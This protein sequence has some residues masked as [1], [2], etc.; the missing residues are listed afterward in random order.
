MWDEPPPTAGSNVSIIPYALGGISKNYEKKQPTEYKKNIGGDVKIAVTSSL[1]LDLTVNPDF[2]QTDVDQQIVNLDRYELFFP[3]KR[4]FFL[5][6]ADLFAN[7]GYANIRPFF[8]RRIGLNAPIRF[9]ARLS[10]KLNKDWRIGFM[11]M[12]TGSVAETGLPAQNFGVIALQRRVFAR[13]NIGFIFVNKQ[14]LNYTPGADSSKPVYSLYNRNA[15]L[16]YNLAS[17]NNQWTGKLL[18]LKSFNDGPNKK[19]GCTLPIFS[20]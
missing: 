19:I 10:G 17:A 8:S 6:N 18:F 2:S 11:D 13:S 12:Q 15:G 16:E 20:T 7:F 1:N 3:E 4:Q 5:E 9:G 14:S